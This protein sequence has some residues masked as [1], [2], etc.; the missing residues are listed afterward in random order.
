[1]SSAKQS[2]VLDINLIFVTF[3]VCFHLT[4]KDVT[5]SSQHM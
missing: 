1:L 2:T 4:Q 5:I 3:K